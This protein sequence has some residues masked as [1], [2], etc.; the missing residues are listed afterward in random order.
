MS[1]RILHITDRLSERGGADWYILG[2]LRRLAL[3]HDVLLACGR[4]EQLG[5]EGT[6][7]QVALVPG[8]DR[9][10]PRP[11]AARLDEVAAS[12]EPEVIHIH[13]ALN[14]ETLRWAAD[15]GAV[16]TVHDHRSFCPGRGKLTRHGE[17]C[18][19]P[20]RATRCADCFADRAYFERIYAVTEARLAALQRMR[21]L[22]VLSRYMKDELSAVGIAA[23][24]VAVIPPFVH[25]LKLHG[26]ELPRS[27]V[28][29]APCVL[30]A[31][32]LVTAKGIAEAIAAWRR[33]GVGLPL[34]IAGTGSLRAAVEEQARDWDIEL[35]GWLAHEQMAAHYARA[36][37]VLIPSLWQ[38][39]FGIV[40]LEALTANT[41]VVAFDSG[42][43]R[44]WCPPQSLVP[45]GDVD[46]LAEG[47]RQIINAPAGDL[48][49]LC[50][51]RFAPERLM[52][53]LVGLYQELVAQP[54]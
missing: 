51:E 9:A 11:L 42:G 50:G 39:P 49:P 24:R 3:K 54:L 45:W 35:L 14:P 13:N 37:A 48:A 5:D 17:V 22:T 28:S 33:S 8:L 19:E 26:L 47:L 53:Q 29:Q 6:P 46:A 36:R 20:M 15:R 27:A 44:D 52:E 43:I 40:G 31:G 12:F 1:L 16:A 21:R 23:E 38:E 30:F 7:F 4:R 2:V 10:A 32:R 41:P 18:R 25:G 34:A